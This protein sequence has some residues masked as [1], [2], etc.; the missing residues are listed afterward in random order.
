MVVGGVLERHLKIFN[1]SSGFSAYSLSPSLLG[2]EVSDYSGATAAEFHSF[3]FDEGLFS[4]CR[5]VCILAD[6]IITSIVFNQY[7]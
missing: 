3:P 6:R 2:S 1:S 7:R 5:S 4:E